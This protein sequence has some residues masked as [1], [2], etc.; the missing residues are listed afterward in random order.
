MSSYILISSQTLGSNTTTVT[1]NSV[2]TTLNGK[3]L[4]DLV[5]VIDGAGGNGDFYPRLRFN[6][7]T[8][9]NYHW[10]SAQGN[11]SS[12]STFT[13]SGENGQQLSNGVFFSTSQRT[14]IYSQVFDFTQTNKHKSVLSRA[15]RGNQGTEMLSGR[16][17]STSAITSVLLYSGNGNS[18]ATGTVVSLYGIEG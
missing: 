3:T 8:G 6:S 18:L 10:V 1:F 7:D 11:G 5:L 14:M 16:W 13:G 4:R 2:P 17:A 9:T 12:A 15:N